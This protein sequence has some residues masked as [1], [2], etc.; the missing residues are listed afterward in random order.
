M[1]F[2]NDPEKKQRVLTMS[3]LLTDNEYS[4]TAMKLKDEASV[5]KSSSTPSKNKH[6][7]VK[8]EEN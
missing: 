6:V 5:D 7:S 4:S 3:S 1:K 8:V 2:L